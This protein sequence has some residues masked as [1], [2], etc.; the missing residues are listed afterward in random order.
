MVLYD[1]T[2][3]TF[4]SL[5]YIEPRYKRALSMQ[6]I[7]G[8]ATT[9]IWGS[10]TKRL[11]QLVASRSSGKMMSRSWNSISLSPL[12]STL[13]PISFIKWCSTLLSPISSLSFSSFKGKKVA[14]FRFFAIDSFLVVGLVLCCEK[15]RRLSYLQMGLMS[16]GYDRCGRLQSFVVA[17]SWILEGRALFICALGVCWRIGGGRGVREGRVEKWSG[18]FV[19]RRERRFEGY[20]DEL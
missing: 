4:V 6:K 20:I 9:Y 13:F 10:T 7:P 3:I 2:R 1:G 8:I 16:L 11:G 18:P 17:C 12:R 5:P 15:L 14:R 19:Y